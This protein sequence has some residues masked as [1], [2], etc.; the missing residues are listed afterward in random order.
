MTRRK[1]EITLPEIKRKWPHHVA[2]SADKV[3]GV[4]NSEIVWSFAG[5]L[6]EAPRPY[7]LHRDDG[8]RVV[9]CFAKPEDA[10]VF[11]ERFDGAVAGD[12]TVRCAALPRGVNLVSPGW[13]CPD[14]IAHNCVISPRAT[15]SARHSTDFHAPFA[16][17]ILPAGRIDAH[18]PSLT[19]PRHLPRCAGLCRRCLRNTFQAG[20]CG[21]V[22]PAV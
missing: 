9:F 7:S 16:T 12:G 22:L 21:R 19:G 3:R 10:D 1:G 18:S 13:Y 20:R 14:G 17:V 5:A 15:P 11:A 6:S 2:I 4:R 8:D